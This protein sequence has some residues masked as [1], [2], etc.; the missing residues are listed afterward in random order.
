ML[1]SCSLSAWGGDREIAPAEGYAKLSTAALSLVRGLRK[2]V[3]GSVTI[4]ILHGGDR[5]HKLLAI[6]HRSA[7]LDRAKANQA[8]GKVKIDKVIRHAYSDPGELRK[9]L[10][11]SGARILVIGT[12]LTRSLKEIL[13]EAKAVKALTLGC[14]ASQTRLGVGFAVVRLNRRLRMFINRKACLQAGF[15]FSNAVLKRATIVDRKKK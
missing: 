7:F 9:L 2:V 8:L 1:F 4:V 6:D 13:K 11:T 5:S 10:K 15:R 12:G 3:G 14:R